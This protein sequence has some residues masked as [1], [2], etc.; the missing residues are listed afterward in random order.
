MRRRKLSRSSSKRMFK[1]NT[2]VQKLNRLN[3]R[4]FRG[5]IRL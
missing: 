5:G 2:G 1:K 4:T 3:P